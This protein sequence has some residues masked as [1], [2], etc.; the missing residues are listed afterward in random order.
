MKRVYICRD[1]VTGLY[2]AVYDAWSECRNDGEAGIALKDHIVPELFCEYVETREAE[3]K[4]LAVEKLIRSH[5]GEY[6][7]GRLYYASLSYEAD[8]GDA[9]FGTMRAARKLTDSTRIMDHLTEP[10]VR[11]CF[12]L[13]R[14]VGNEAHFFKEFLRFRELKSGVLFAKIEPK[15][16]VLTCIAPHFADRLPLENWMIYDKTHGMF[17]VHEARKKWVLVSDVC[18]DESRFDEFSESEEEIQ[19]LWKGFFHTISIEERESYARQ[20]QHL[21]IWYR[22]NMVEFDE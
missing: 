12:E 1:T 15:N 10:S 4:A 19:K 14:N 2:S 11:R 3:K 6:A 20:R 5:L 13:S 8:K 7:Y 18:A 17:V 9:I 21:P 16:Q 22:K